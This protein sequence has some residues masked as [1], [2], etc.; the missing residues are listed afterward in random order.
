MSLPFS[1][2]LTAAAINLVV[3]LVLALPGWAADPR[4]AVALEDGWHFKQA[5]GLAGVES[6]TFDDASWS[7]VAVPHTWNRIGNEGLERS[8][9]SNNVQ[10][11]GWYRLHFNAPTSPKGARYFLQFDGVGTIA[12]VWLNG[13]YLGKHAGAF[14]RFRFDASA[15]IHPS[16][17]N[18]LVV[19]ADN[20]LA[21]IPAQQRR[22]SFRFRAIFSCSAASTE[23][24][25]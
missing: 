16:G 11:I 25:H 7:K 14:A 3:I 8:P 23:T 19:Q 22:T 20:S 17:D 24:C 6:G 2:C 9:A 13:T 4:A 10:G 5:S 12:Q 21:V 18:L 1:R 15:A